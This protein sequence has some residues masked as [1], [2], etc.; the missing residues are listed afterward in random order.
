M[1]ST[2]RMGCWWDATRTGC[3]CVKKCDECLVGWKDQGEVEVEEDWGSLRVVVS[4]EGRRDHRGG[5]TR[6]SPSRAASRPARLHECYVCLWIKKEL[7]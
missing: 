2:G 3:G 5:R 4:P 1:H 7:G 6:M